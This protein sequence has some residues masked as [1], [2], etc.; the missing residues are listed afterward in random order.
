KRIFTILVMVVA[1]IGTTMA[2]KKT[3]VATTQ[4]SV[5]CIVMDTTNALLPGA[6]VSITCGTK[7]SFTTDVDGRV[8]V[9]MTGQTAKVKVTNEGYKTQSLTLQAGTREQ[10]IR[11]VPEKQKEVVAYGRGGHTLGISKDAVYFTTSAKSSYPIRGAASIT[12]E[13]AV[14]AD[15]AVYEEEPIVVTG[16]GSSSNSARAGLLTAG[17]VN[18]FAKWTL[19]DSI[20]LGSHA[21][22][23]PK[24][25]L[26]LTQRFTVQ[27]TNQ[28]GY[29]LANRY[30]ALTDSRG[31][32]LF[33]ARTDN[34]GKAEL[35]GSLTRKQ[36]QDG[37]YVTAEGQRVQA[38]PYNEGLIRIVTDEPCGAQ[39]EA[40]VLFV[41]DATG[42]MGDELRYL[43]AEM[44]DVIRRSQGAVEGL[45]IRTGALVY[46]DHGDDYLTRIS[47][48]T[49]DINLTQQF[50]DRQHANG[51]GDFE[52]AVPEALKAALNVADWNDEARARILFLVLDAPCHDDSATI[53]MLHEQVRNAAAMGVRIVPVVCSGLDKSGELL[54]R[55]I[56][57]TTNGTSFFLTD[58]SGIG[59]EHLKPTTDSL[60]VEHL[61]DMLV[62]TIVEF[63][64]M[65]NCEPGVAEEEQQ[66]EEGQFVPNPFKAEDLAANPDL[67]HGPTTLYLIDVSG[68]LL[69]ILEGDM[70]G[71]TAEQLSA[72]YGLSTGVYFLKAFYDGQWHTRK[73]L[74]RGL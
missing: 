1:M 48:L 57:L 53:Q 8:V 17:E 74:V 25:G 19:W 73:L 18:D 65:P 27:L 2:C 3:T 6:K 11:L 23:V 29:P 60:K 12:E 58:D 13:A 4:D 52:E 44:K 40:D 55:E 70:Q 10:I 41:I 45:K 5:V 16:Y 68:K 62:R 47:R 42:S 32:T 72:R 37:L 21:K 43:C 20:V 15:A 31:T 69:T 46:R 56:A 54:M 7:R 50:L 38:R 63:T 33:Q 39:D 59:G 26:H 67:P 35:W 28:K 34:T 51:G 30:V 66:D 71:M 24:W 14:M 61:N 36:A 64:T 49:S 9:K 22:F